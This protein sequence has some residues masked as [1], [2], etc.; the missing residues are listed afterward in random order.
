MATGNVSSFLSK[1]TTPVLIVKPE[2]FRI[3]KFVPHTLEHN[4]YLPSK[5]VCYSDAVSQHRISNPYYK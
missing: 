5:L 3:S 4:Q 1:E 2:T